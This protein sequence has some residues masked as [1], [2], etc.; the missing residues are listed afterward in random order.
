ML[1]PANHLLS[2]EITMK[3][4]NMA[5]KKITGV[6]TCYREI[7]IHQLVESR[8]GGT[9]AS[10]TERILQVSFVQLTLIQE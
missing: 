7:S 5:H 2:R 10:L 8:F 1:S 9:T 3:S 4:E 6:K